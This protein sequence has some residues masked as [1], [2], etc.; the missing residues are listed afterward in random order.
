MSELKCSPYIK[1]L[2][3]GTV[4]IGLKRKRKE[5]AESPCIIVRVWD[6]I[7]AVPSNL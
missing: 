6:G 1:V 2:I 5:K 4:S 7:I 3:L